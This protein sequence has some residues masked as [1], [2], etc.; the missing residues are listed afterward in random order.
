MVEPGSTSSSIPSRPDSLHWREIAV[1]AFDIVVVVGL[2]RKGGVGEFCVA[3]GRRKG[4]KKT[5]HCIGLP[6]AGS[7]LTLLRPQLLRRSTRSRPSLVVFISPLL[8]LVD[9]PFPVVLVSLPSSLSFLPSSLSFLLLSYLY[10][11]SPFSVTRSFVE[12]A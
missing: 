6:L 7:P 12:R 2:S 5:T 8:L 4:E 11:P 3:D 9:S 1:K 10:T